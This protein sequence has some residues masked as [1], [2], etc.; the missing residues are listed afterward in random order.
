MPTKMIPRDLTKVIIVEMSA[1]GIN[2]DD[3]AFRVDRTAEF[4]EIGNCD[5]GAMVVPSLPETMGKT[6]LLALYCE[7][8]ASGALVNK[9]TVLI[10]D[11][12]AFS[13]NYGDTLIE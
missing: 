3:D 12:S 11:A 13:T 2:S 1:F 9:G 7:A 5:T 6:S 10:L 8:T 4:V